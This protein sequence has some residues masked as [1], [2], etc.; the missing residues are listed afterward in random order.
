M[1]NVLPFQRIHHAPVRTR[2]TPEQEAAAQAILLSTVETLTP[3][4]VCAEC[5]GP[6]RPEM[7][8]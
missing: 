1:D 7:E 6:V 2:V 3:G 4:C 5:G 8:P